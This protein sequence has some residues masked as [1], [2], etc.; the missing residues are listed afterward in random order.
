MS[1]FTIYSAKGVVRCVAEQIEFNSQWMAESSVTATIRSPY[2]IAFE[3]GDYIEYRGIHYTL[4]YS[5]T[6]RKT[7]SPHSSLDAFAYDDVK[8]NGPE[9]ELVRCRFLDFVASDNQVHYSHLPRFS[10]FCASIYDFIDRLQVNVDRLYDNWT[11]R[12]GGDESDASAA[13]NVFVEIDNQSVWDALGLVASKFK[14]SFVV[15]QT[16]EDGIRKNVVTIGRTAVLSNDVL[17]Y[18]KGN[19]LDGVTKDGEQ[20]QMVIT[21]LRAY[22][23]KKN[24][25]EDYYTAAYDPWFRMPQTDFAFSVLGYFPTQD[26]SSLYSDKMD[27]IFSGLT[28][29]M[30]VFFDEDVNDLYRAEYIPRTDGEPSKFLIYGIDLSNDDFS[31]TRNTITITSGVPKKYIEHHTEYWIDTRL[32]APN[33]MAVRNLMLPDFLS[34]YAELNGEE[35][36]LNPTQVDLV[37]DANGNV[38]GYY[39]REEKATYTP[40]YEADRVTP[41]LKYD[42]YIDA[43]FDDEDYVAKYGIREGCVYFESE[44]EDDELLEICPTLKGVTKDELTASGYKITLPDGDNGHMDE[45]LVGTDSTENGDTYANYTIDDDGK[46]TTEEQEEI[47]KKGFYVEIKDI[48][49]DIKDYLSTENAVLHMVDGPC[50]A[51]DFELV[52]S[53]NNPQHIERTGYS[54]WKIWLTRTYDEALGIYFPNK[55]YPIK[56]GNQFTLLN[57]EM[58]RVYVDAASERL[59]T[60]ALEYLQKNC[61]PKPTYTPHLDK[62]KMARDLDA[63]GV[64]SLHYRLASGV[65]MRFK[66]VDLGID[67]DG[68][69]TKLYIDSLTIREKS[70]ALPEYEVQ[71]KEEKEYST[72]QKI[73]NDIAEVRSSV[74]TNGVSTADVRNIAMTIGDDRYVSKKK[75]DVVEGVI[76]FEQAPRL[77]AGFITGDFEVGSQGVGVYQRDENW[78]TETDYVTIRKKLYAKEVEIQ[79]TRHIGGSQIMSATRCKLSHV[80]DYSTYYRAYFLKKD[81]MGNAISNDWEIGDQA[82]MMT[83]NLVYDEHGMTGNR[84]YWRVVVGVGTQEEGDCHWVDLSNEAVLSA[85]D[86]ASV[87]DMRGYD[88]GSCAPQSDDDVVQLGNRLGVSGRVSA[89]VLSGAGDD[90]PYI[91]QYDGIT[92]FALGDADVQIKPGN[93]L[94]KGRLTITEGSYGLRNFTDLSDAVNESV[95]IGGEN[96]L[97][98]SGFDGEYESVDP[99]AEK[100]EVGTE[101]YNDPFKFWTVTGECESVD[102]ETAK[103]GKACRFASATD[104][105]AQTITLEKD[106]YYTI[107]FKSYGQ[108]TIAIDGAYTTLGQTGLASDSHFDVKGSG[109][110]TSIL[111][112]AREANLELW[113]VKLEKGRIVTAWTPSV[114]DTDPVADRFKSLWYLRDA[115]RNGSTDILGGLLLSS[116]VQCGMFR[117][118]E[119]QSVTAGISGVMNDGDD[120]AFWAG[121]A[122]EEAVASIN[123]V[124]SGQPITDD[125]WKALIGFAATHG[126]DMF[127]KGYIYAKGGVFRGTVYAN[128]GVFNGTVNATDGVFRGKIEA[129]EGYFLGSTRNVM[130]EITPDNFGDY[131]KETNIA[132][133]FIPDFDKIGYCMRFKGEFTPATAKVIELPKLYRND[134]QTQ[135]ER[136]KVRTLNSNRVL[137]YNESNITIKFQGVKGVDTESGHLNTDYFTFAPNTWGIL[138]GDIQN[139]EENTQISEAERGETLV[140]TGTLGTSIIDENASVE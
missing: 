56:K 108:V 66:D 42:T 140:W 79:R 106:A 128:D 32:F 43:I 22:G 93:S 45:L 36:L 104:K 86:F 120:V 55:D 124:R 131:T 98:N 33:N 1:K 102:H 83:F 40:I 89:I 14:T 6:A 110:Q 95:Q 15:E 135:A 77:D 129:T 136:D 101:L 72:I 70:D 75:N 25:P 116:I 24:L 44:N 103:S 76:S 5:P 84:Y 64:D 54:S 107:S 60:A 59:K 114:Q 62:I 123:K 94:F 20:N 69:N 132:D 61:K 10:F 119:M 11:I 53:T 65:I 111:F 112:V 38:T 100:L 134:E 138:K 30:T 68:V 67:V 17:T 85:D 139:Y 7:H 39:H 81:G 26:H 63:H 80:E 73:Q 92:T 23:S 105:I 50:G 137:I 41:K 115:L 19:G 34:Y 35:C 31:F 126:G 122:Y 90:S 82:Y 130:T 133:L 37:R 57:I 48:G 13:H 3:L 121:G 96:L 52:D 109:L 99:S 97:R 51:R 29:N 49:F 8:F 21:R 87:S 46:S 78:H 71:L 125:E 113:D 58:P 127:L 18:G 4:N 16:V 28:L 27:V 9:D 2:P 74:I 12:W 91:K 88:E 117:D 118:G 47:I